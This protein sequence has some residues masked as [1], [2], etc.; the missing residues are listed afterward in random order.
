MNEETSSNIQ[1]PKSGVQIG[2]EAARTAASIGTAASK[3]ASQNYVGAAVEVLKDQHARNVVI[4]IILIPIIL[5]SII[6]VFFLYALPTTMWEAVQTFFAM[7]KEGFLEDV[8]SGEYG[9]T[10]QSFFPAL[11]NAVGNA[12]S[13]AASN[14]WNA[15]KG[16]FTN[17]STQ[18]DEEL[19]F[20]NGDQL[21]IAQSEQAETDTLN[22]KIQATKDKFENRME[23][24]AQ[25]VIDSLV[26]QKAVKAEWKEDYGSKG[27]T[28][29]WYDNG[30]GPY[31]SKTA[32]TPGEYRIIYVYEYGGCDVQYS[33]IA[34]TSLDC[35]K[36]MCVYTAQEG[37]N[38]SDMLLSDYMKWL[39]Y[40]PGVL[41]P[42]AA[43]NNFSVTSNGLTVNS[44][45]RWDGTCLPQ[46]LYEQKEYEEF[47]Y[48]DAL[49]NYEKNYGVSVVDMLT[50]LSLPNVSGITPISSTKTEE[51]RESTE[52]EI[53]YQPTQ[54]EIE[55]A[56]AAGLP[57]PTT[58]WELWHY[59]T[60]TITYTHSYATSFSLSTRS[61]DIL[62]DLLGITG[63]KEAA[64]AFGLGEVA[65]EEDVAA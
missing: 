24:I 8:Y 6:S 63:Y 17:D 19:D 51:V 64:E 52:W 26:I 48:G 10:W 25:T 58:K 30:T 60:Y 2:A 65:E 37:A 1:E 21:L 33:T 34:P 44:I 42:G 36:I 59:Y 4:A 61:A 28:T 39:G 45:R 31:A 15:F 35:A 38:I 16:L 12:I 57:V 9:S 18:S 46:Y 55:A 3:V 32:G 62:V 40:K 54:R 49:V 7:L 11:R 56:E 50:V 5:F 22:D 23:S 43:K 20:L 27:K 53:I 29:V 47:A 13:T 14:I 41:F